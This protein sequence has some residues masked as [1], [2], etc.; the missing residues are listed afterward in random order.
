M[1][2]AEVA[3]KMG[4]CQEVDYCTLIQTGLPDIHKLMP[5][6]QRGILKE[7]EQYQQKKEIPEDFEKD[8]M[9]ILNKQLYDKEI[10]SIE[11]YLKA[12]AD[13]EKL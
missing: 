1:Y 11:L 2:V 10:I 12:K 7:K 9:F 6:N 3:P 5:E 13:I 4:S 8:I